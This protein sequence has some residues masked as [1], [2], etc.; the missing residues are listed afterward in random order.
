[1]EGGSESLIGFRC[2]RE[3]RRRSIS[4]G[5]IDLRKESMTM[6][7]WDRLS[8]ETSVKVVAASGSALAE[9]WAMPKKGPFS[10]RSGRCL[11]HRTHGTLAAKAVR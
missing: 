9:A 4:T 3:N 2:D 5:F 1:M 6:K 7:K 10:D 8:E 11:R